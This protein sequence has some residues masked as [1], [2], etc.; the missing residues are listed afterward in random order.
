VSRVAVAIAGSPDCPAIRAGRPPT[1]AG[2]GYP[3]LAVHRNVLSLLL[4]LPALPGIGCPTSDT[5][6]SG[7]A[8]QMAAQRSGARKPI[9]LAQ[10]LAERAAELPDLERRALLD[11]L[12]RRAEGGQL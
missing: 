5:Q 8:R 6:V 7:A 12:T 10:E 9:R 11:A 1:C 4:S 2:G 3:L